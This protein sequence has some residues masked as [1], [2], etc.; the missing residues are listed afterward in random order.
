M[1]SWGPA[2]MSLFT[3]SGFSFYKAMLPNFWW[4][5]GL[6]GLGKAVPVD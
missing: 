4:T 2:S 1:K 6:H 5:S 3:G